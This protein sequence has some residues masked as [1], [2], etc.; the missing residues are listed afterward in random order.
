[1]TIG[2]CGK[3]RPAPPGCWRLFSTFEAGGL[4]TGPVSSRQGQTALNRD[5][6]GSVSHAADLSHRHP[7]RAHQRPMYQ[8]CAANHSDWTAPP[9]TLQPNSAPAK[10]IPQ[11]C[12]VRALLLEPRGTSPPRRQPQRSGRGVNGSTTDLGAG[13]IYRVPP[14]TPRVDLGE[15]RSGSKCCFRCLLSAAV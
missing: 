14:G 7:L 9:R 6:W 1:M 5:R 4:V 3:S 12:M 13:A 8:P 2:F 10:T 11:Q 15:D